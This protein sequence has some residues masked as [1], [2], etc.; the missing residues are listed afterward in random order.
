MTPTDSAAHRPP[1]FKRAAHVRMSVPS[2]MAPVRRST[3][4]VL[5]WC[6]PRSFD[7][8]LCLT[9][10]DDW[11]TR[12]RSEHAPLKGGTASAAPTGVWSGIGDSSSPVAG[13]R[14]ARGQARKAQALCRWCAAEATA[15][16][17]QGPPD[18]TPANPGRP[19]GAPLTQDQ[20]QRTPGFSSGDR[21][22]QE[23]RPPC[24]CVP[25]VNC[26]LTFAGLARRCSG[27]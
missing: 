4:S 25:R 11:W 9:C 24:S 6:Y 2:A 21:Y 17:A 23:R 7:D 5:M 27:T 15:G 18:R 3:S 16:P 12:E 1:G 10:R 8:S 26:T 20:A 22:G 13:D 14:H 19:L